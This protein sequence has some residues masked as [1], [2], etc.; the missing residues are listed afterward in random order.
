MI[1]KRDHDRLARDARGASARGPRAA[2]TSHAPPPCPRLAALH[3]PPAARAPC[4][5]NPSLPTAAP[6]NNP[7]LPTAHPPLPTTRPSQPPDR[8][9][10][11]ARRPRPSPAVTARCAWVPLPITRFKQAGRP[12]HVSAAT[13]AATRREGLAQGTRPQGFRARG[14]RAR[15][16]VRHTARENPE[17]S[18]PH[19]ARR[20][21]NRMGHPPAILPR[22]PA[23]GNRPPAARAPLPRLPPQRRESP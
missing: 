13:H 21:G 1:P 10:C 15:G 2:P 8:P 17:R 3:P 18:G 6:P 16:P 7:P 20:G 9:K 11:P 22:R 23:R 5:S 12:W 4:A 19:A 14:N